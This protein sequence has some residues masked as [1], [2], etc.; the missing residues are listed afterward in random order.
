MINASMRCLTLTRLQK[1]LM[2]GR[3]TS[4][5]TIQMVFI[6]NVCVRQSVCVCDREKQNHDPINTNDCNCEPLIILQQIVKKDLTDMTGCVLSTSFGSQN[7]VCSPTSNDTTQ[8]NEWVLYQSRNSVDGRTRVRFR[9]ETKT[10]TNPRW[11]QQNNL[12]SSLEQR[13]AY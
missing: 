3:E 10:F 4:I 9:C 6:S 11:I 12:I 7:S 13:E 8:Q 2:V 5:Q 1:S